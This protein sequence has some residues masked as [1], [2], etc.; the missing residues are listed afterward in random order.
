[1]G[2]I[3]YL[4]LAT[5]QLNTDLLDICSS[6]S[7]LVEPL[8]E[9]DLLLD[10]SPFNRIA[11]IL[12]LL[13]ISLN[14]LEMGP[15]FIGLA[16]SPLL[17]T[18]AVKRQNW[19]QSARGCCRRR[20]RH[21]TEIIQVI[22][23]REA[24]FMKTL[25]LEEFPPLT[26]LEIKKLKRLGYTLVGDLAALGAG[27]LQQVIKRDASGLWHNSCGRDYRPVKGLY[28]FECLGYSLVLE[29][30]QDLQLLWKQICLD[31]ASLLE[32]RHAACQ[33]IRIHLQRLPVSL[34]RL[35][36]GALEPQR[37]PKIVQRLRI[38]GAK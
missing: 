18:L 14:E 30:N 12:E 27:R 35:V 37:H 2:K 11:E 36:K 9:S 5:A 17:A 7:N 22:A 31:L 34:H 6:H 10:L 25:L 21:G 29:D 20:Q 15:A 33:N 24:D 32:E 38:R 28:P 3:I 26:A 13:T 1:M 4:S 19:N 16:A 8:G 23:G